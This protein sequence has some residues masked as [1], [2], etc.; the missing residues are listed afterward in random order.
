MAK[1]VKSM[2]TIANEFNEA[3]EDAKNEARN[4]NI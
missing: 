3:Q 2:A 4:H 1:H